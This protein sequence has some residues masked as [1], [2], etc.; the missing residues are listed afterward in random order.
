MPAWRPRVLGGDV[1]APNGRIEASITSTK[2]GPVSA[3]TKWIPVEIIALYQ[4]VTAPFGKTIGLWFPYLIPTGV[5]MTFL[6]IAFA[7]ENSNKNS[8]IAWRQIVLS[9]IAFLAWVVGTTSSD[10]WATLFPHWLPGIG[11]A[12]LAFGT[13]LLPI[14]DGVMRRLG[15]PQD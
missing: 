13:A 12:V 15:V 14:A 8:R 11:P 1:Y 7:T 9:C 4:G 3:I 6:W 2:D 5:V 10:T